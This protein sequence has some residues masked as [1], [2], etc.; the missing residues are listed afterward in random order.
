VLWALCQ[1]FMAAGHIV[2]VEG[3]DAD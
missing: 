1:I 2:V 3:A